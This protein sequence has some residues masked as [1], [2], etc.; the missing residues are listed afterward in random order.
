[1]NHTHNKLQKEALDGSYFEENTGFW[2]FLWP[3]DILFSSYFCIIISKWSKKIILKNKQEAIAGA[4][5]ESKA[6]YFPT[7]SPLVCI[8]LVSLYK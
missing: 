1:M 2:Q 3:I 7:V 8:Y 5:V 4:E 6:L